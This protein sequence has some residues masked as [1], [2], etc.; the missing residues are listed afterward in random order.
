M[1][2]PALLGAIDDRD[3]ARLKAPKNVNPQVVVIATS[4]SHSSHALEES[5]K[6]S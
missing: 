3:P 5:M 6:T 1:E 4:A 2:D